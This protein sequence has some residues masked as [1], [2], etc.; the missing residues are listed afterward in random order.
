MGGFLANLQALGFW[1]GPFVLLD[2]IPAFLHT[3]GWAACF[4]DKRHHIRLWQLYLVRLAGSAINQVT[5]TATIGGEV[6]KV[7]L[8]K[9]SLPR[10]QAAASVVIDKASITLAQ[11]LYLALGTLYLTGH[12]PLPEELRL[13]LSLALGLISLGLVGFVASQ[14][15][16]LLSRLV[17]GLSHLKIGQARLQRLSQ[18][19][20]PLDTYLIAYYTTQPWRFVGSI[21]WHFLAFAFGGAKT[22]ILL[23]FLLGDKAPDF[24]HA[25]MVAVSVNALDQMF[26]FVPARLGTLEG[27]RFTVL[28]TLGVAQVYGLAFGLVARLDDLF[29]NGLGLLAYALCTRLSL[30]PRQGRV[31]ILPTVGLHGTG[32]TP[33]TPERTG[34]R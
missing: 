34:R 8:L 20:I 33:S 17:H 23:R 14:R 29:W 7:L 13:G 26:F 5:P 10:E 25:V 27:V 6:V 3:A 18:R 21:V 24:A 22:Y 16:G 11:I 28:S 30:L 19:L 15:Y 2:T 9:P 12:L 1:V 31:A 32:P 4:Q